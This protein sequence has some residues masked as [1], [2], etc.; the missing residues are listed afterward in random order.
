MWWGKFFY[1]NIREE[2]ERYVYDKMLTNL[3]RKFGAA[4][5]IRSRE[6]FPEMRIFLLFFFFTYYFY[7]EIHPKLLW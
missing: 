1:T 5:K 2:K 3:S 7:F 4:V 6:N